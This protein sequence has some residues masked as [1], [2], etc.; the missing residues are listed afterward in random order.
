M[1]EQARNWALRLLALGIAI[2]IWFNASVEDR[3]ASNEKVVEANVSYNRPRGFIIINPV[4]TVNVRLIG[5]KKA[6]RQL[7]PYMV[8]V[9]VEL[10]Q[11][12]EGSATLTLGPENVLA[13]SGLE[14]VSIEPSTIRV[15]LEREVTER[16]PVSPKLVGEPAAGAIA[17]EPEVFP[18][19]VLVT[20][21][22]SMLARVE[23]LSTPP[24]SLE[25]HALSFELQVPVL[26][27]DPLIQI[28]QPSKV[29]VRIPLRQPGEQAGTPPKP[30]K[31]QT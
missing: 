23:S 6:I 21:P 5:S 19:Q 12:Q 2:G 29:T 15:E 16:L 14:V 25:G 17:E 18:S 9:A 3:L 1:S 11:R 30:R 31:E 22:A 26:P 20:G 24:I 7:N 8:D 4:R 13:P 10:S 27:P 28:V